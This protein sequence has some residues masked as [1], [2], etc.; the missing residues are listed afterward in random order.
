MISMVLW[1]KDAA[2]AP[3][4]DNPRRTVASSFLRSRQEPGRYAAGGYCN[5]S[6][7]GNESRMLI[8]ELNKSQTQMISFADATTTATEQWCIFRI[9]GVGK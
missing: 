5:V 9:L 4:Q 3:N 2:G 7:R 1:I 6:R 8:V